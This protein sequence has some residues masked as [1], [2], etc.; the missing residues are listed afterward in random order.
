MQI[1]SASST[2]SLSRA[3]VLCSYLCS[4]V[5]LLGDLDGVIDLDA[6]VAH[7]AFDLRMSEQK[8]HGSEVA[9][10]PV[11]Q[12]RL[13]ASQRVRAE[14]R[15]VEPDAGHPFLHEPSVLPRGQSALAVA[16][17]GEQELTRPSD[18]SASG[19]RRSPCR[20]WSVSSNRTGLPVFFCR[21]VAR[22]IA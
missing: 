15:R 4:D 9:G 5:D 18:R 6:E 16:T 8:L 2:F 20:V 12:H 11:D 14:L 22:S 3:A 19:S 17:T 1:K 7:G 10:S 21:M 13:R